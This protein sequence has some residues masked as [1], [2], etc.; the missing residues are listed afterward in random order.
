MR[1]TPAVSSPIEPLQLAELFALE[2]TLSPYRSGMRELYMHLN[3][4][5]DCD[6]EDSSNF[7]SEG[8]NDRS[9][10]AYSVSASFFALDFCPV[11]TPFTAACS[12]STIAMSMNIR[13][14]C[15]TR[16]ELGRSRR[17]RMFGQVRAQ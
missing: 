2:V 8:M 12:A 10:C 5:N 7:Q 6:G 4:A 3:P 13:A 9:R 1:L 14:R 16:A 15:R 11:R 17:F